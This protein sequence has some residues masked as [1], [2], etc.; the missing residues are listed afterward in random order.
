MNHAIWL[1]ANEAG[2]SRIVHGQYA[3]FIALPATR[4]EFQT[5]KSV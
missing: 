3:I 4:A 5:E 2:F 1:A